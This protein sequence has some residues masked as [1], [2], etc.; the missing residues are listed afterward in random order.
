M[1][2]AIYARYSSENQRASS[3]ED[4]VSLCRQEA[5]RRGWTV[6]REWTDAGVSGAVGEDQ[7]PGFRE[8]M[9]AAKRREFDVVVV[10]D[11]SRLSRDTSDALVALKTLE[12]SASRWLRGRTA[13]TRPT[14]SRDR[15]SSTASRAL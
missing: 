15:A 1:R 7:R 13:S 2:A 3:I 12:T 6:A 11:L 9:A 10:D 8:M 5:E 4:Q 14:A